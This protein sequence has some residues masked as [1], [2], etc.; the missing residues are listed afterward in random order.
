M[1]RKLVAR[2]VLAAC[3]L[4]SATAIA[5]SSLGATQTQSTRSANLSIS[6]NKT[7]AQPANLFHQTQGQAFNVKAQSVSVT[8]ANGFL[9]VQMTDGTLVQRTGPEAGRQQNFS[10]LLVNF[11]TNGEM[12]DYRV[13]PK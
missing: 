13:V 11:N 9:A 12:M 1:T 4:V 5:T 6:F 10:R 3:V 8:Q 2:A 7:D